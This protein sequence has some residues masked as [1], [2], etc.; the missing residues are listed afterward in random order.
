M[1]T[2]IQV[3]DSLTANLA[4]AAL[5]SCARDPHAAT[6]QYVLDNAMYEN[7]LL[8]CDVYEDRLKRYCYVCMCVCIYLYVYEV[9]VQQQLHMC[10]T[11]PCTKTSFFPVMCT[12][13]DSKG[14]TMYACMYVGMYV[15]IYVCMYV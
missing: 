2:H 10:L 12:R 6:T 7:Q 4:S 5:P 3:G 15:C 9:S 1:Y 13:T 11:T 14:M 8:P